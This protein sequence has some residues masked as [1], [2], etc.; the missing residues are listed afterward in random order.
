MRGSTSFKTT[1]SSRI[2]RSDKYFN[3]V[4][5][6][7]ADLAEGMAYPD[8]YLFP[9]TEIMFIYELAQERGAL[10]KRWTGY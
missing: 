2:G 7:G 4:N 6:I 9:K 1:L 8:H 10:P 5:E 3:T